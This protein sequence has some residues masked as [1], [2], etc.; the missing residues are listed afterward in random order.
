MKRRLYNLFLIPHGIHL[1]L[2]KLYKYEDGVFAVT[3]T[4][5]KWKNIVPHELKDVSRP[6]PSDAIIQKI[7]ST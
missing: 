6:K 2:I 5:K 4:N 1:P 3:C 7:A